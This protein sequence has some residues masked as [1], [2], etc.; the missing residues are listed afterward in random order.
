M[1]TI[2]P[3]LAGDAIEILLRHLRRGRKLRERAAGRQMQDGE[4]D[5]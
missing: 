3:E 2:E 4:A 1:R 5:R